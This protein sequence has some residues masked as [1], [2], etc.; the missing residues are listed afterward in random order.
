M[1]APIKL[2]QI[3][4]VHFIDRGRRG[5]ERIVILLYGLGEDG[6]AYEFSK[7]GWLQLPGISPGTKYQVVLGRAISLAVSL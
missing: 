6:R 5:G 3:Q 4:V 7:G 1:A 2:T